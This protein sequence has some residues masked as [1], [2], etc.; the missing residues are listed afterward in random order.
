MNYTPDNFLKLDFASGEH[1]TV[2]CLIC[3]T[4]DTLPVTDAFVE[5]SVKIN[6]NNRAGWLHIKTPKQKLAYFEGVHL[7]LHFN[8]SK[9]EN[10]RA[11]KKAAT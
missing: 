6:T 10:Q 7:K 3:G 4:S 2:R 11:K 5:Y 9:R 1:N 8:I